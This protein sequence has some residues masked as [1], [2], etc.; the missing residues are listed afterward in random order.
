MICIPANNSLLRITTP[1]FATAYHIAGTVSG[2]GS[3][4]SLTFIRLAGEDSDFQQYITIHGNRFE[5][6]LPAGTYTTVPITSSYQEP[7]LSSGTI[8]V[9]RDLSDVHVFFSPA[10]SIPVK[11]L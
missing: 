1:G 7:E 10:P 8:E 2:L 3:G 9:N 11:I 5:C 4:N 6:L